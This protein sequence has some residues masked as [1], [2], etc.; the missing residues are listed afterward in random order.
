VGGEEIRYTHMRVADIDLLGRDM[1]IG[2]DFFLSHRVYVANSQHRIYFTYNGGPVFNISTGG[3]TTTQNAGSPGEPAT[4]PTAD[5]D[6]LARRG[7]AESARRDFAGG[8]ADL[9]RARAAAP[10]NGDYAYQLAIAHLGNHQRPLAT[11]DLNDAIKLEPDNI[12]ALVFRAQLNLAGGDKAHAMADLDAAD[13]AAAKVADVRLALAELYMRAD[14]PAAAIA[15][16]DLWLRSHPDD[17]GRPTALNGGCW[18]RTILDR[19]LDKA[20]ADCDAALRLNGKL[21]GVLDSRGLV[22][23]RLGQFAKAIT[24]Y[25]AALALDPKRAWSLYGRGVARSRLGMTVEG[26]ADIAA[27]TALA[28]TLPATAKGYGA[29]P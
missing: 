22:H 26:K 19:E 8:V 6:A 1:W 20:L 12:T 4:A 5:A 17:V 28:P 2:A 7:A 16:Y 25:D 9:T 3:V 24:D 29:A 10:G 18:S 21:P 23:L 13:H 15:Q 14:A 27:A 11:A